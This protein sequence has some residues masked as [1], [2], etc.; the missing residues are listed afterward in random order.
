MPRGEQHAR[1]PWHLMLGVGQAMIALGDRAR[2]VLGDAKEHV[3][4][5]HLRLAGFDLRVVEGTSPSLPGSDPMAP[6]YC[7]E[8]LAKPF[9]APVPADLAWYSGVLRSY[10]EGTGDLRSPYALVARLAGRK[11]KDSSDPMREGDRW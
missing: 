9:V 5:R 6:I 1:V 10:L 11:K 4:L 3:A 2:V 7:Q 8:V